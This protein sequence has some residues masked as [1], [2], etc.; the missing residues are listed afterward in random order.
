MDDFLFFPKNTEENKVTIPADINKEV[1][2][3][4]APERQKN[5]LFYAKRRGGTP[6]TLFDSWYYKCAEFASAFYLH[7]SHQLPLVSPDTKIY[8]SSEKN[9]NADL[10]YKEVNFLN[11]YFEEL[12]FHNKSVTRARISSGYPESFMFQLANKN[13][14]QGGRDNLLDNGNEN[15][16]CIFVHVPYDTIVPGK[17]DFYIRGVFPWNFIKEND[18]LEN[19]VNKNLIGGKLCVYTESIKRRIKKHEMAV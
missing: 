13:S 2:E 11:K 16:Y 9:W 3:K 14:S 1:A 6:P 12:R 18:L 4:Y 8:K 15:D 19:P 7:Q 10:S 17:V 5:A